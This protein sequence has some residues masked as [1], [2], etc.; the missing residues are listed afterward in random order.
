M[1]EVTSKMITAVMMDY[2]V[3][4]EGEHVY[5]ETSKVMLSR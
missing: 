2:L 5:R 1:E 4:H 3:C